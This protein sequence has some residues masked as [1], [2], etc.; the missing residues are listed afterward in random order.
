MTTQFEFRPIVRQAVGHAVQA[1]AR[2]LHW[3]VLFAA[4]FAVIS[5]LQAMAPAAPDWAMALAFSALFAAGCLWSTAL[6]QQM[7]SRVGTRRLRP[8]TVRLVIANS[9]VY[10]LFVLVS[11]IAA[12]ALIIVSGV[13][14][15]ASGFDPSQ[16]P[17]DDVSGSML[18]LRDSGAIWFL[19]AAGL[20]TLA[21]LAWF[22]VRLLAF[23]AAT[24]ALGRVVVFQ[25]WSW[26]KGRMAGL[27]GLVIILQLA[28]L[29]ILGG[30]NE[31]LAHIFGIS[32]ILSPDAAMQPSLVSNGLY[33]LIWMLIMSPYIALGHG[34][35]T[36]VYK[37]LSPPNS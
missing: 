4:V 1:Y 17:S 25:T 3:L 12:L 23:G 22:A 10:M 29:L 28:P 13:L 7:L 24:I 31:G 37:R 2:T 26:T 6:Y 33:G 21:A 8:D 34:L 35:S 20:V 36:V 30:V 27:L 11:F 9:L 5:S 19:Y 32:T 16:A 18:A 15:A 14:T